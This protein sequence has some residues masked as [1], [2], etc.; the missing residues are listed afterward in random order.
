MV[1]S[2]RLLT[3]FLGC[4]LLGA[5]TALPPSGAPPPP[6]LRFSIELAVS[7][8]SAAET[9]GGPVVLGEAGEGVHAL[10]DSSVRIETG[11]PESNEAI[12]IRIL[13]KTSSTLRL[14]W[15]EAAFIDTDDEA[16]RVM[17]VGIRFKER[18]WSMPASIIPPG[19][20][21]TDQITPINRVRYAEGRYGA[22]R[23][24]TSALLSQT[25][26]QEGARIG[27]LLPFEVD[28][29]RM[30]YTVYLTVTPVPSDASAE[31]P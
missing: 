6:E 22:W 5:C 15:N 20:T 7:R 4:A 23:T 14:L 26:L 17:H 8:D 24:E 19:S 10:E 13:N 3:A 1:T 29:Q 16:S 11:F 28:G 9:R 21:H 2:L 30:E 25:N 27:V 12:P 31:T 18:D